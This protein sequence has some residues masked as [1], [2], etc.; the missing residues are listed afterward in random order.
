MLGDP[1]RSKAGV[2]GTDSEGRQRLRSY[3]AATADGLRGLIM[4]GASKDDPRVEAAIEWLRA[5][6]A[7][8]DVPHLEFYAAWARREAEALL[9]ESLSP[10][11]KTPPSSNPFSEPSMVSSETQYAIRKYPGPPNPVPG[12]VSTSFFWSAPTK[13]TS[14]SMGDFGKR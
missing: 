1:Y 5:H 9:E 3:T 2:A 6:P 8:N 4:T 12:T 14:S 7:L 13:L 10:E 11:P